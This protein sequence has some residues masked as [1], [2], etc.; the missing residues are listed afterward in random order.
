LNLLRSGRSPTN[1]HERMVV[2]NYAAMQDIKRWTGGDLTIERLHALQKTL[3]NGTLDDAGQAGR[4]R[5]EAD[6]INVV[7]VRTN[8]IVFTPPPANGLPG[9][10]QKICDFANQTHTG[11]R[12]IHPI[13]KACILHFMIGYEHPYCD[14]NG[15]T[16]RAVFYW[17]ALKSG[18]RVFEY[19]VISELIRKSWAR[20]GTAYLN[21]ELDDGDLTYFIFYKLRMISMSIDRLIQH[22]EDEEAKIGRSLNLAA[23]DPTLNLRQ[24]LLLDHA[25]R[26]P[27]TVYTVKSH[28][29]SNRITPNTSRTDLNDLARRKLLNTFAAGRTVSYIL[30][31][32]AHDRLER[33]SAK[34]S[35]RRQR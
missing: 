2:N 4:F 27:R 20:Y 28:S 19:M 11:D 16:A 15:R 21:T 33:L 26:H 7:D 10:V 13:V 1:T 25:L 31:P 5:V 9:R 32:D 14:G 30:A 17:F 23:A 18:Y 24:R 3:T 12:F 22:I 6:R 34:S 8:D 35:R 29:T